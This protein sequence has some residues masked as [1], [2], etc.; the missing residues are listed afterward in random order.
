ML[1]SEV[2]N[3]LQ[4]LT[5]TPPS[6]RWL[7]IIFPSTNFAPT[8]TQF[9]RNY[10]IFYSEEWDSKFLFEIDTSWR[11]FFVFQTGDHDYVDE[12][13][14]MDSVTEPQKENFGDCYF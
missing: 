4:A 13:M 10:L 14:K 11:P 12:W 9:C 7:E 1:R 2:I 5:D 8:F 3:E 6:L